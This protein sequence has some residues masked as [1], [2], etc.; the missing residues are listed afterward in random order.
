MTPASTSG[1]VDDQEGG[2]EDVQI[3]DLY[4][5]VRYVNKGDSMKAVMATLAKVAGS[6][7]RHL[8]RV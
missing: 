8:L 1:A 6:A 3:L 7:G 2:H 4:E 5:Y